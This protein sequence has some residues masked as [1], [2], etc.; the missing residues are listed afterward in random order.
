MRPK[1]FAY[2]FKRFPV[3]AQTFICREVEGVLRHGR[4]PLIYSIQKP[5]D[6]ERQDGFLD[7]ETR[8]HVLPSK[9]RL[10]AH[11]LKNASTGR[12]RTCQWLNL[13]WAKR[14]ARARREALW[15]G[16]E[17]ASQ[18]V[19]HLHTHFTGEA[20]RTAWWIN[21][22]FGIPYSIT[23]HANDFLC[24]TNQ[25][26]P[27]LMDLVNN[28]R[29]VIS[30]SDFSMRW[31][32]NKFPNAKIRRVYNGINLEE[33]QPAGVPSRDR[34][35]SIG[36]LVEKKG[37]PDLLKA[38]AQIRSMGHTFH[39]DIVGEGPYR[40]RLET[41]VGDLQLQEHVTLHGAQSQSFIKNLLQS[42][43]IFALACIEEHDGGMD[44]LPT[45]I[46][47]AMAFAIPV[48]STRLA[49]IP[50]MV[51]DKKTGILAEPNNP[52]QLAAALSKLLSQPQMA[53]EM[54]AAGRK[55]AEQIFDE[56]VTIPELLNILEQA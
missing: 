46:T 44:I 36:R 8:V 16:P 49:G 22:E 34:I 45:V 7:M 21:K 43:S 4:H 15:L 35:L 53:R 14:H 31:F 33:Y 55:R 13:S 41:L 11:L 23:A 1:K 32:Q 27:T 52:P 28:A 50:E 3:F 37:F 17:L 5:E 39:C 38:C 26:S 47:E 12:L 56:R 40:S 54:G 48:V 51:V 9:A 25:R 42:S 10:A 29:S 6:A 30:V 24:P 2:I 18:A 19:T 20:A